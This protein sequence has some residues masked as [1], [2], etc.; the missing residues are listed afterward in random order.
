VDGGLYV[1]DVD[2]E[3]RVPPRKTMGRNVSRLEAFLPQDATARLAREDE[4]KAS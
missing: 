1:V 2:C 4:A 3:A